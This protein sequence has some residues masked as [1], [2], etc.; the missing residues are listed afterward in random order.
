MFSISLTNINYHDNDHDDD[1]DGNDDD[2]DEVDVINLT[3]QYF[4]PW[5]TTLLVVCASPLLPKHH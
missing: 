3:D 5:R 2:D 1:H 4:S